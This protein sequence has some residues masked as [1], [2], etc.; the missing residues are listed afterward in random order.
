MRTRSLGSVVEVSAGQPAP[1]ASEFADEGFPF[2]RAGSLVSL[3]NGGSLADC[4]KVPEE[5]ARI[6]KLRLYPKDTIVFA[7]S[8]MSATLGR[9]YRLPEPAYVVSHLAALVPTGTYDPGYL[10]HWLR[11]NPPSQLIR[12]Q[13]YPSIR[14]SEIE[15]MQVPDLAHPEQQRIAA[16]L[17]K[18]DDI[19]RKPEQALAL[20]DN[21]LRSVFIEMFGFEKF[22][23]R[24]ASY[25]SIQ[26]LLDDGSI[27]DVQDGNHGEIHPKS[28]DFSDRGIPF[29]T[30]SMIRSGHITIDEAHHLGKEWMHKLRIGFSRPGDVLLSHKG[31]IGFSAIVSDDTPNLILSPQVT[32][33]RPNR[34]RLLPDFL[35]AYFRSRWFQSALEKFSKQSTRAYIGITRQK[36]LEILVPPMDLQ[37]EFTAISKRVTMMNST[38]TNAVAEAHNLFSSVSQRAFHGEL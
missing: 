31:S 10:S 24:S 17:D 18:A 35:L 11:D 20:A 30:A 25:R 19:R 9:V 32:Y 1:S 14:V 37:M 4:E 16:I 26:S 36:A 3:L 22:P 6:K 5:T 27:I 23:S 8:G 2:V 38:L 13:A 33:Y 29:V 15:D 12:D 34:E 7:K 21:L 28:R